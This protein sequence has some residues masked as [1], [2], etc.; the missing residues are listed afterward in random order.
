MLNVVVNKNK[1][2]LTRQIDALKSTLKT[3]LSEKD[4][5]IFT[6]TIKVLEAELNK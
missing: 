5:I 1:D 4:R 3:N 6:D 2:K